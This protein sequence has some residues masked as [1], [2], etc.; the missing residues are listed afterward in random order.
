MVRL[1]KLRFVVA[2]SRVSRGGRDTTVYCLRLLVMFFSIT[3]WLSPPPKPLRCRTS[4]FHRHLSSGSVS[5]PNASPTSTQP[6]ARAK[7]KHHLYIL[8]VVSIQE[9][10]L[11]F[12]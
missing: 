12:P 2:L 4:R 1:K 3:P 6:Q 7:F 11:H 8:F 10:F 9:L 5:C